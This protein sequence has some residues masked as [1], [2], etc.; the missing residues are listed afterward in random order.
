MALTDIAKLRLEVGDT[1]VCFPILDDSSYD[2]FLSKHN[3]SISRAALDAARAILFQLSTMNSETVS[4]FS[5]KN[6]SAE[7]YRQALLLYIKDQNLNPLYQNLQG[8]FGGLSISD[9]EANNSNAD[10]NIVVNPGKTETLYQ[11]GP[12]TL[13]SRF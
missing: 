4:I 10:N 3:N 1:E 9:M 13:G 6:T 5:V 7:S 2:Y 12:F 11:T 8:Y